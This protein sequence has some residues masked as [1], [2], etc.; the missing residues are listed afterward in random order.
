MQANKKRVKFEKEK[1]EEL[2]LFLKTHL[3][4]RADL[5]SAVQHILGVEYDKEDLTAPNLKRIKEEVFFCRSCN[6]WFDADKESEDQIRTCTEC[7]Y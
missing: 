6:E 4:R 2:I 1:I 3:G 7:V 5:T